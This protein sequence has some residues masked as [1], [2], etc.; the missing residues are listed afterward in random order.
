MRVGIIGLGW[1]GKAMLQLFPD[2]EI[3]SHGIIKHDGEWMEKAYLA[4][5]KDR[6]K[7]KRLINKCDIVFICLPTPCP[8]NKRLNTL[9]VQKAIRWCKAPMIVIRSTVNTGDTYRWSMMFKNH[10]VFQPE[11]LG[12]TPNHPLLNT[13]QTPFLIIGGKQPDRRKLIDLY[14]TVYNANVKIR[15][16]DDY[17]AEVIKLTENR[18][19]TFKVAQCQELYDVCEKS[20]TD[21]YTVRDAVFGDDPRMNL[22]WTMV[23]PNKRGINSKCMPK[24]V[25]AWAAWAE[26]NG[27][28]PKITQAILKKNKEWIK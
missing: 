26:S 11:Y 17:T 15:Q 24:D 27:Y 6:A 23:Y 12:E 20:G 1:V 10:I 7:Y 2:A 5:N 18:A 13:S 4:W 22:W 14:T 16:T 25:Y 21:Y 3:Y 28:K 9:A 19:I 8:R